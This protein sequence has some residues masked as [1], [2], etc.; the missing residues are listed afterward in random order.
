MDDSTV[1]AVA[2]ATCE[3]GCFETVDCVRHGGTRDPGLI[4]QDSHWDRFRLN[5]EQQ[6]ENRE[7]E[8]AQLVTSEGAPEAAAQSLGDAKMSKSKRAT[9]GIDPVPLAGECEESPR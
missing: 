2:R 9:R 1:T 5:F 4:G 6:D 3:P 7:L 8:I